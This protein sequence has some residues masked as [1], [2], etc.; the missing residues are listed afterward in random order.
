MINLQIIQKQQNR[1]T[2]PLST[3]SIGRRPLCTWGLLTIS[4]FL[5]A[6]EEELQQQNERL[7]KQLVAPTKAKSSYKAS[8]AK[9]MY[10]YRYMDEWK[11]LVRSGP[12]R[13]RGIHANQSRNIHKEGRCTS[14]QTSFGGS[15]QNTVR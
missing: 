4:I 6:E 7:E 9:A 14:T 11:S 15:S 10:N 5:E 3:V 1:L 2:P 13:I 12:V 8:K